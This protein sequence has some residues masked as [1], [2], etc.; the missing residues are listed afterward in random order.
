[1]FFFSFVQWRIILLKL[2]SEGTLGSLG[3]STVSYNRQQPVAFTRF[4]FLVALFTPFI[5]MSN[6]F[7]FQRCHLHTFECNLLGVFFGC[8]SLSIIL[9]ARFV[10]TSMRQFRQLNC[11]SPDLCCF[12]TFRTIILKV[13]VN[14]SVR[15]ISSEILKPAYLMV[16]LHHPKCPHQVWQDYM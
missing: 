15:L 9:K 13:Y 5:S 6:M 2:P 12:R 7:R 8:C 14:I 4:L 16:R 1:M 11:C 3:M 10:L